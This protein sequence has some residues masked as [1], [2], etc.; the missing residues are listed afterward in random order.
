MVEDFISYNDDKKH[1]ILVAE[2]SVIIQKIMDQILEFNNYNRLFAA[3]GTLALEIIKNKKV[4]LLI[5]DINM[6]GMNGIELIKKLNEENIKIPYILMTDQDIDKFLKIALENDIGNILSK[7]LKKDEVLSLIYKHITQKGFFGLE[8]YLYFGIEELKRIKIVSSNQIE[9]GIDLIIE[10]AINH[11]MPSELQLQFK[12]ILM[13]LISNAVYHS[14]GR[15]DLKLQRKHYNLPE[16]KYVEIKYGYDGHKFGVGITDF[17]GT[18]SKKIIIETLIDLRD[19][20]KKIN[21]ALKKGED[22]SKYLKT[23]GRGLH[24]T[25]ELS[26]EYCFNIQRGVKTEVIILATFS[27]DEKKKVRSH[28]IKINEIY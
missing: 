14:H 26:P 20:D 17:M 15:T 6:P 3:N 21:E 23:S 13:E 10:S 2:D 7:P 11:G 22:I 9:K 8:N 1:T 27:E 24:I 19:R 18:L 4:D 16:G 25:R 12:L 5:S 28:Q